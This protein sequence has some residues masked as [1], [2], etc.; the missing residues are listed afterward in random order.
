MPCIQSSGCS[1]K[2]S[3]LDE[4]HPQALHEQAYRTLY[5]LGSPEY[6]VRCPRRPCAVTNQMDLRDCIL[7]PESLDVGGLFIHRFAIVGHDSKKVPHVCQ[8]NS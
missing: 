5:I 3:P 4:V 6:S 1:W 2:K 7:W 8:K